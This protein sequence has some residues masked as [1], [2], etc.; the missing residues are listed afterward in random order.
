MVIIMDMQTGEG[1]AEPVDPYGEEV[2]NANWLP[3]PELA[4]GMQQAEHGM[5]PSPVAPQDVDAFLSA[6][7]RYQE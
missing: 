3:G 1:V 5:E 4:L 6:V 2:L 7:Y